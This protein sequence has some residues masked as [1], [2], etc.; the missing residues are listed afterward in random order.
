MEI[1]QPTTRKPLNKKKL[2]G[3]LRQTVSE[4]IGDKVP[5]LGA[6]L[7]YYTIFS[8]AP[9]LIISIAMAG[10]FLGQEAAQGRVFEEV[11]GLLGD[12]GGRAIQDMV[13][14]AGSNPSS[15]VIATLIGMG[16]LLL[17]ASGVFG[18]VQASLNIMWGV[19]GKPGRGMRGLLKDR[20]LSFGFILV[21]G[22]LLL[23]S[24]LLSAAIAFLAEWMG[25][26]TPS[27]ELLAHVLNFGLSFGIITVLF[28]L[29]FKYLPDVKIVWKDVWLG[30]V[31][32]AALFT[33][34]KTALGLYLGR[35]A[36]GSSY[37]AAGS[38]VVLLLWVYYSAQILFFGAEFTQV[39]ANC[40]GSHVSPDGDSVSTD[41]PKV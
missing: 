4:W 12:E 32:T 19:E 36:V 2:L 15:G 41:E 16:T 14:S 28:A 35:S 27:L 30:A 11:R 33:L 29:M 39:W 10:I 6:A 31:I 38:L 7:A 37:G 1:Y 8:L 40:F 13:R 24:L 23:V 21:V 5:M 26:I 18:Q 3:V 34:G 9:L 25:Q 17:G 20:F 22:F